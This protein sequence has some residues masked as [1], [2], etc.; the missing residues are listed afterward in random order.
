MA[1]YLIASGGAGDRVPASRRMPLP[2]HATS[3]GLVTWTKDSRNP[4]G[5]YVVASLTLTRLADDSLA[6]GHFDGWAARDDGPAGSLPLPSA[7]LDRVAPVTGWELQ[8]GVGELGLLA[9]PGAYEDFRLTGTLRIDAPVG[10]YF[11]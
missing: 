5:K 11:V 9:A 2:G 1:A 7:S 3:P 10:G 4:H 8:T 6:C